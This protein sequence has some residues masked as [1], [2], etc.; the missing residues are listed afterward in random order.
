MSTFIAETPYHKTVVFGDLDINVS[1]IKSV[2][3]IDNLDVK[4]SFIL[5]IT[6]ERDFSYAKYERIYDIILTYFT[7]K[8]R[9]DK[10][11]AFMK[12]FSI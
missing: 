3:K 1:N 11:S 7:E 10:F 2:V 9:D 4:I 8:E 12:V 5:P 6:N